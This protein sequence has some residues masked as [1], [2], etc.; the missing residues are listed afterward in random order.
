MEDKQTAGAHNFK[1]RTWDKEKYAKLAEEK[2]YADAEFE[3]KQEE[4][5][6]KPEPIVPGPEGLARVPGSQRAFLQTPTEKVD[7]E[8]NV[9]KRKV[10]SWAR[11]C[12]TVVADNWVPGRH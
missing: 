5:A 10:R 6:K 9:G 11:R 2:L 7:L 4:Q 1:R 12:R 8:S 3:K